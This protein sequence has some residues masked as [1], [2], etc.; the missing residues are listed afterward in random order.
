MTEVQEKAP[1]YKHDIVLV[2]VK[3]K[4]I[5]FMTII[6]RVGYIIRLY[7]VLRLHGK[8][9]VYSLKIKQF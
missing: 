5:G 7:I 4:C 1:D 2:N 3:V 9:I 6:I 8:Y